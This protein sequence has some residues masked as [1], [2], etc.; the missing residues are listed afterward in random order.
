[1]KKKT[2]NNLKFPKDFL[3]G[4]ATSAY[5]IEG[6]NSNSDWWRWEE[7]GKT[8]EK[9]G[10]ACDYWHKFKEDHNLLEELGVNS[11]R[12]SLEWA[13]IEPAE[14]CFSRENLDYYRKILKD[15]KSRKIKTVVTL[16]HWTSPLWFADK[17]GF[18]HK[19]SSEI[20]SRY[21][22][23]VRDEL[24]DWIDIYVVFNEPM[25]PLGM[26]YLGGAF[27][28]GYKNP[29]KFYRA[30]S[31]IT[32]AYIK[33]YEIIHQKYPQSQ[34]GISYLYNWYE[35]K[36]FGP[37]G[38]LNKISQWFRIDLLGNKIKDY[39]DYI[40][41]DYYRIGRM[42]FNR[43]RI[44]LD[45]KNQNYFGFTVE[46]DKKNV[47]KWIT[48]PEGIYKVLKE[49][50]EKYK[51]PIYIL[52]NGLP[53]NIGLDDWQR[54]DFIESHLKFVKKALSE[55]VDVKGYFHWSLLD[56][57][58]WL[59]GYGPRFGLVE[60]DYKTL[61]RKP[62]KSFYTYGKIIAENSNLSASESIMHTK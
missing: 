57:Y 58:E 20:F 28:P 4:A 32:R 17:Y 31:N 3:W 5:Q 7:M 36:G 22:Q 34:V 21:C 16:W 41:I 51:L 13:S 11:Y 38:L 12:L 29:F 37:V 46:E 61:E 50:Q 52:E 55:G 6:N 23:K 59:Y 62:R 49:A 56:N 18:H 40:G 24:G 15:L 35:E 45:A 26:G 60:I 25:V 10:R 39:Q 47:M 14:N 43:R 44:K 1:M 2:K 42:K 54:I 19:K 48:Y 8:K 33:V 53:T 30:L 27:P 9:S